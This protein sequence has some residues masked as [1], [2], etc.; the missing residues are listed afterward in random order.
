MYNA[1]SIRMTSETVTG[2]T[3]NAMDKSHTHHFKREGGEIK[4]A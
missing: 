3:N 2:T 1:I 4:E